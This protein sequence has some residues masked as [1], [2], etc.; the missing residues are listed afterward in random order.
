MT[1]TRTYTAAGKATIEIGFED[2][3]TKTL[4]GERCR[5]AVAAVVCQL[6]DNMEPQSWPNGW[7]GWHCEGVRKS[8]YAAD[9]LRTKILKAKTWNGHE[10]LSVKVLIVP[11]HPSDTPNR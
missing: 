1:I 3:T 2:G 7:K 4:R 6:G 9:Q 8:V 5:R 10:V 11:D